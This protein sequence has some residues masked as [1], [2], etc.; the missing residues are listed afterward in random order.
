[1]IDDAQRKSAL[2]AQG[3]A[4]R[5]AIVDA[6]AAVRSGLNADTLAAG[7]VQQIA[8]HGTSLISTLLSLNSLRKGDLRAAI[9]LIT[10]GV[11]LLSRRGVGGPAVRGAAA[12]AAAGVAAYFFIRKRRARKPAST[13]AS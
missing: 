11:S 4:Y 3:A 13:L 5:G 7:A 10:A 12:L 6:R 9:P 8:L 2:I 1:M